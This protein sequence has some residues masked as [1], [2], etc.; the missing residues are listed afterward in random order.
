MLSHVG[1]AVD[2]S[3]FK[4]ILQVLFSKFYVNLQLKTF[5]FEVLQE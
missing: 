1:C 5:Q 2:Y 3:T 4:N